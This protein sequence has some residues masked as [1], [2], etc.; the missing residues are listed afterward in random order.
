M[1]NENK[2]LLEKEI[3]ELMKLRGQERAADT[4][5]LIEYVKGKEG[6]EGYDK[7]I[8]ELKKFGF[9]VPDL[10]QA[11][12]TDWISETVAHVFFIGACRVFDWN[13]EEIFKMGRGI[14][15]FSKTLKIFVKYFYSP[16]KTIQKTADS[17]NKYFSYGRIKLL[18]FD[19]VKKEGLMELHDFKSHPLVC[20]YFSGIFSEILELATGSKKAM[21]K[22]TKCMFGGN[23]CHEF[24]L[25]W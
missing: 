4:K 14:M 20:L 15:S 11:N 21:V 22:E 1:T 6:S 13:E 19:A 8:V 2:K 24:K 9:I 18:N 16:E 12:D 23:N 10:S 3:P 5:Y 17:W 25:S 7:L